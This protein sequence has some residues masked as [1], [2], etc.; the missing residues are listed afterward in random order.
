MNG[1]GVYGESRG[2]SGEGVVGHG[3]ATGVRGESGLDSA[4]TDGGVVGSSYGNNG[5]GVRGLANIGTNSWAI[6]GESTNGYAG[7]FQG[8]VHVTGNLS[9]SNLSA[10]GNKQFKI[11]HPL[12][13]ANKYLYHAAIE[14]PD[15]MNV[16]NGNVTLDDAGEAVI[17]LPAYFEALNRDFRYQLT[18]IGGFAPVYVADEISG[19]QFRIAGGA[20]SMKVSW[21][22]TGIRQDAYAKAHPLVVEEEKPTEEKGYYLHPVEHGQPESLAIGKRK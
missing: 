11:D 2:D 14:S 12:D 8:K 6:N 15:V 9:A 13:P 5:I 16:Y 7:Y 18:C 10:S 22:V 1:V 20:P 19:N 21:Q 4:T 3:S 17:E